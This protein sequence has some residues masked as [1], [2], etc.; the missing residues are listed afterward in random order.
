MDFVTSDYYLYFLPAAFVLAMWLGLGIRKYQISI[1]V[2]MSYLFFWFASGWHLILLLISTCVDWTAGSKIAKSEDGLIKKRWLKLSLV[3]N[4]TIL[5]LF[6]YLDFIIESINW[7]SLKIPGSP[8]MDTF[9]LALPVG[10]SFYT[11]QTMSY[12]ID[13]YRD[14]S[15]K[16]DSFLDFACYA[17]FFPQLVA[18]PIVRADHF[19]KEIAEPLAMNSM[20]FRLG[21]TLIIYGIA[22]KFIVADNVALHANYIFT[23]GE[24]LA[25]IGLIWWGTLCFGIQ[26]YCDFSAYTDIAIGSAYLLGVKLPENFKTPY[27]ATSPQDFWRR[28][29]ISL[30]TW[31]RDYLYIPL[32]GSR[33]GT[34]R[35]IF[36]LMMTM[37]LGGLWH[38]ASW[39]F[40][41]WGFVHGLLLI[42]HRFGKEIPVI[43]NFFTKSGRFG[44]LISWLITQICVFF[45]WM[46]FR[47]EDTSVLLPSMKTFFG[48]GGHFDLDEMY[49]FLPE[50]KLLTGIIV[51]G[52]IILHGI[53]GKLGGGKLWLSRRNSIVWG[54]ICGS[55]LTLS[56]YLRPS[57]TIDFIYFRF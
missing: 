36:A 53:S 12:T 51:L 57:E 50:I 39:N 42:I 44:L 23:E 55:A 3:T 38:G 24:H 48:I 8:E 17:A 1:L 2:L 49:N 10:I 20:K 32:G 6:K 34:K 29:H 35:M 47:I 56:F 5:G 18:G 33:N 16:Y 9:G 40:I 46:I 30:S 13:I 43:S 7:V 52:F 27:A 15:K 4:L 28:W 26:I 14:E 31:L 25:N 11:F 19:R 21:L 37:L 54:V 41:L 22:K 45:T